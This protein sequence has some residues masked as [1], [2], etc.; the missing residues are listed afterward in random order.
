MSR[1]VSCEAHALRGEVRM[2]SRGGGRSRAG[3]TERSAEMAVLS[4]GFMWILGLITK[5]GGHGCVTEHFNLPRTS[6]PLIN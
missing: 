6:H 3:A 2:S 1:P 4:G 5:V